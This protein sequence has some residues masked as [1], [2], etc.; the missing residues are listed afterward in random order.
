MVFFKRLHRKLD[1][2][3]ERTGKIMADLQNISADLDQIKEGVIAAN[4]KLAEQTQIIA[5]LTAQLA[6]GVPVTQADLDALDAKTE[7]IKGLL[8]PAV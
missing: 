1:L 5:D 6:N 7:E 3:V 4:V 8:N 2:I